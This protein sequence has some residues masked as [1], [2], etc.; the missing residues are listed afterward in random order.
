M[1]TLVKELLF[2][3][4]IHRKAEGA[5][6]FISALIESLHDSL[7]SAQLEKRR[8][9]SDHLAGRISDERVGRAVEIIEESSSS[10]SLAEVAK[11]SG[12]SGRNFSRLFLKEVGLSPKD[13]LILRRIEKAKDLLRNSKM[14][15]TDISLEVGYNSLSKFIATF[16]RIEGVLPSDYRSR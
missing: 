4:L 10:L 6:Y 5:Q 7:Q 2:Y 13:F 1:N 12:L 11:K 3:L 8:V 16:R 15:V 14:T 9:Y